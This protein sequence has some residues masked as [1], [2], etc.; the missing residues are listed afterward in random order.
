MLLMQFRLET[1]R[2]FKSIIILV[3]EQLLDN[4]NRII[5]IKM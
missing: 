4:K 2:N 3:S 5:M 1:E